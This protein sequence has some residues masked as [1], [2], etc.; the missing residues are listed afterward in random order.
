MTYI[1]KTRDYWKVEQ[2][3]GSQYGWEE[4]C[5]SYNRNEARANCKEYREN[6]PEY[7]V[8]LRKTRDPIE[9]KEILNVTCQRCGAQIK[10]FVWEGD[11]L[12]Q[13]KTSDGAR[14]SPSKQIITCQCSPYAQ[15]YLSNYGIRI[16]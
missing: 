15:F 11:N 12:T 2:Y 3:T 13:Y 9:W 4:F 1:R 16:R 7:P 5:G 6:Q 14:L 10:L 8:R